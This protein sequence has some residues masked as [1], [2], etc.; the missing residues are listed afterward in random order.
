VERGML[1]S[2]FHCQLSCDFS[3]LLQAIRSL[4][5]A[6]RDTMVKKQAAT[7]VRYEITQNDLP[8]SC[9]MPNM[10]LWD[11]HP[12]VFLPI[13]ETGVFSCPYCNTEY[14]LKDH[15]RK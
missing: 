2:S 11:A 6:W 9:P 3:K 10:Y 15:G 8:L 7:A 1:C 5:M 4:P 13:E 12:K 14:Y